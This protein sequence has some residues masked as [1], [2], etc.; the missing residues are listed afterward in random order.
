MYNMGWQDRSIGGNIQEHVDIQECALKSVL[1]DAY[2]HDH[3]DLGKTVSQSC[4]GS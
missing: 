1:S 4:L 2:L 3:C